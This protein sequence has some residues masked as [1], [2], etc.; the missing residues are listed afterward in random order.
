M[1]FIHE[2][3]L[4]YKFETFIN[5]KEVKHIMVM[6]IAVIYIFLSY[7]IFDQQLKITFRKSAAPLKKATSSPF[8]SLKIFQL[9]PQQ[10]W[11][12][13]GGGGQDA[14]YSKNG[15]ILPNFGLIK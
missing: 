1:I 4:V 11:V 3:F 13:L 9:P 8:Y 7:E 14:F 2:K 6:I 10:N 15:L 5:S 12:G